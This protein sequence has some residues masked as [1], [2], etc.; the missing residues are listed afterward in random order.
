[1]PAAP[2]R[3]VLRLI[4]LAALAALPL[5]APAAAQD[6]AGARPRIVGGYPV[7]HARF[8]WQ[9]A[10]LQAGVADNG[11]AQFC[12]GAMISRDWVVTAAH[13]VVDTPPGI[14]R[15]RPGDVLRP[16]SVAVLTGTDELRAGGVRRSVAEV[17]IHPGYDPCTLA[18]DIALMRLSPDTRAAARSAAERTAPV[19]QTRSY[20]QP[21]TPVT[22]LGWGQMLARSG[23]RPTQLHAVDLEIVDM[24]TCRRTVGAALPDFALGPEQIC[25]WYPAGGR[26]SCQG[27]S[28]GPLVTPHPDRPGAFILVGVVSWGDGCARPEMPGVYTRVSAFI[29]W[30]RN[31]TGR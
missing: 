10:L 24:E 11:R 19:T 28:G 21:G 9:V 1:M 25:A 18:N 16:A 14:C 23:T 5:A 26:D 17:V 22:V 12:G 2:T 30:I 20:E 4:A 8:P 29:P 3:S 31:T 15:P 13:C 7:E 6:R 27:D